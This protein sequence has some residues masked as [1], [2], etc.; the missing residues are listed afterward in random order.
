MV[1]AYKVALRRH[2]FVTRGNHE[3]L[4]VSEGTF[5]AECVN[6]LTDYPSA[7]EEFHD[8]FDSIPYG[9]VVDEQ[10][11]VCHGGLCPGMDL[12]FLKIA[13]RKVF[14]YANT[15]E[16]YSFLWNDPCD[17]SEEY[18]NKYGMA[19]ST[20]GK[21]CAKFNE[22]VTSD[23]LKRHDLELLI[24]SHQ[25]VPLGAKYCHDGKCLTIFSAPNYRGGTNRGAVLVIDEENYGIKSMRNTNK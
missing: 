23:F 15:Y 10:F 19:P 18:V 8:A 13:Q 20:R 17:G 14:T 21:M 6:R 16:L 2:F 25:V 11:F 7:F 24:R 3:S 9:Y 5:Y 12:E 1:F 22:S 4:S